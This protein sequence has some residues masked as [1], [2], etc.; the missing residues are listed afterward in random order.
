LQK[1]EIVRVVISFVTPSLI[2][3]LPA[4]PP[5]VFNSDKVGTEIQADWH[6]ELDGMRNP[7]HVAWRPEKKFFRVQ[8][9][10]IFVHYT[11]A[12]AAK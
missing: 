10:E 3:S 2:D 1:L 12:A 11:N 9:P 6:R 7:R 8:M 4:D 5:D